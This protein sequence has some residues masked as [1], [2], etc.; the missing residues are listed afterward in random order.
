MGLKSKGS[1]F[2]GYKSFA[3]RAR[4]PRQW[5]CHVSCRHLTGLANRIGPQCAC[6]GLLRDVQV[7]RTSSDGLLRVQ[8][9]R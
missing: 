7:F 6:L 5:L 3:W 1:L 9:A 4:C 2:L 8:R